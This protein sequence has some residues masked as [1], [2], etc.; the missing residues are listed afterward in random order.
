MVCVLL[1]TQGEGE[2]LDPVLN[3][4]PLADIVEGEDYEGVINNVVSYGAF[5]DIG[6]EVCAR[7]AV[8]F[9]YDSWVFGGVSRVTPQ[10]LPA[11]PTSV[12]S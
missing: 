3:Q 2:G 4:I 12:G 1:R 5:V 10:L 7:G 8:L 11:I 9:S 6:S